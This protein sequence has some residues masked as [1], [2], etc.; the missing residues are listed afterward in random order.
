MG[1]RGSLEAGVLNGDG[2]EMTKDDIKYL[3][4]NLEGY[5]RSLDKKDIHWMSRIEF[6][7]EM[8]EFLDWII[9]N[10]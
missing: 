7:I 3:R 8:E 10:R 9:E 4:I 6:I 5:R 2:E 1:Y